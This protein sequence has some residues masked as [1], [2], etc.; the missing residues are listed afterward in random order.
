MVEPYV[1]CVTSNECMVILLSKLKSTLNNGKNKTYIKVAC[2]VTLY[3]FSG[4]MWH[5]LFF[6]STLNARY[7]LE[8][9]FYFYKEE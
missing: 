2:S 9:G 1:A 4:K 8:S 3:M 5:W 6:G 7:L